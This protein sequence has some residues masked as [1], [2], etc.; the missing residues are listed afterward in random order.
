L[1]YDAVKVW[2]DLLVY[3]D[4]VCASF[5][6]VLDILFRVGDHQMCFEGEFSATA[7]SLDDERPHGDVGDEV[8]VHDVDLDALGASGVRFTYLFAQ[9]CE[10]GG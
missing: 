2:A 7:D 9:A 1:L 3:D 8:A 10:V 5:D 4:D 6:E